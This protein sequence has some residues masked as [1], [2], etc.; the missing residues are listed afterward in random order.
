MANQDEALLKEV[1]QDLADE[2]Q[3]AA[4]RKYG[5]ALIGAAAAI[6]VGVGGYQIWNS[7]KDARAER[8]AM[9]FRNAVELLDEDAAAGRTALEAVAEAGGGYGMLAQF[10]RAG[11]FAGNGERLNAI[12]AYR[13][14]Y[15][16][17]GDKRLRELARLRAAYLSLEDGR[18]AVLNDLGDLTAATTING[19]YAREIEALAAMLEKD[20]E[21]A[22][23]LFRQLSID[24]VAPETVRQRAEGFAAMASAGK[25]G[26]NVFGETRVQELIEAVGAQTQDAAEDAAGDDP[27]APA[28]GAEEAG[29]EPD[30]EAPV[31]AGAAPE[32]GQ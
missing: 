22:H 29:D 1:D 25:A 21:A 12:E 3:W 32:Q 6:V 5:P 23:S 7:Q 8:L 18:A 9:E 14:L 13:A 2:R 10:Y 15:N 31:E 17:G 11:S 27:A 16:G 24:L 28:P 30:A 20:F 26:I 4:F 19:V